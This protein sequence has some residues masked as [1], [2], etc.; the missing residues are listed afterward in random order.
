MGV[1][2][3]EANQLGAEPMQTLDV[4][5]PDQ[6]GSVGQIDADLGV[7]G[8]RLLV[9]SGIAM[10]EWDLDSDEVHRNTTVVRLGVYAR[11]LEQW[12]AFVALASIA[13]DETGFVFATDT[14]EVGLDAESGE[15]LL[16]IHTALQ[17]EESSLHRISYQVVATI[18]RISPHIAGKIRWPS[19]LFLPSSEDVGL[20]A[21][22]F[23][24]MANRY[25]RVAGGGPFPVDKLTPLTPGQVVRMDIQ[26]EWCEAL[27]RI[28]N[29]A[30]ATDLQVTVAA[31]S[32]FR[33]GAGGAIGVGQVNGPRIFKLTG[34][35]PSRD[36]IDFV[37]SHLVVR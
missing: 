32:A 35:A 29:P 36:D 8:R 23:S 12:S 16:T 9:L 22:E 15:M 20:A 11:D 37:V 33:A 3:S 25:E 17:G 18:V 31:G 26:G 2:V 6:V 10:T 30:M 14:A 24:I 7:G 5:Y 13:N 28:D 1:A 27:Y 34:S 19:A 21:P 4:R